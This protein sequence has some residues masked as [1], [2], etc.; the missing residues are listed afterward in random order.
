MYATNKFHHFNFKL[1]ADGKYANNKGRTI[2]TFVE[3]LR[4]VRHRF[5]L[6]FFRV[7]RQATCGLVCIA[8]PNEGPR[9]CGLGACVVQPTQ[10]FN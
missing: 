2:G 7:Q 10:S 9:A 6:S 1:E 5:A 8:A 4:Y 3:L